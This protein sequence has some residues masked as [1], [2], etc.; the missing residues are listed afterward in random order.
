MTFLYWLENL[1]VPGLNEIML[2]ITQLG[3]ETAFLVLGLVFFWCVDKRRG[4]YIMSVGFLGIMINQFLKLWFRI[5]RPW[6]KDPNFTILEQARDAASGYSFPSG[7]TQTAAGTFGAIAA[8]AS[9]NWARMICVALAILVGFSR[10]YIGVHTPMD[11]GVSVLIAAIL[12]LVLRPLIMEGNPRTMKLLLSGMLLLAMGLLLFVEFY[13]F[14]P[15]VDAH[16]LTSGVKNAYTMLGSIAGVAVVYAVDEKKLHFSEKASPVGQ[17]VK[18]ILGLAVV[19]AVKEGL[20]TP[21]ELLFSGHMAARAVR[22]FL[23]VIT[24]GV[25]WPMTFPIWTRIGKKEEQV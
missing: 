7:H 2:A 25:L 21:L 6:I 13:P 1:R 14:P 20:R 12:V 16:N 11:V 17:L 10:M 15:D 9:K 4:Y 23:I 22:Y 18:V 8:T 5:P 19:L 24:A 3:E